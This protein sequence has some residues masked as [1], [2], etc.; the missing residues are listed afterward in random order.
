MNHL[1]LGE[2]NPLTHQESIMGAATTSAAATGYPSHI[3]SMDRGASQQIIENNPMLLL[4]SKGPNEG[5][6]EEASSQWE[7]AKIM[8]VSSDSEHTIII[9][10]ISAME[11]RDRKEVEELGDRQ[12]SS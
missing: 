3:S 11:N 2:T 9:N 7:L 8:W 4:K 5:Q 10:K 6:I 12:S 1:K